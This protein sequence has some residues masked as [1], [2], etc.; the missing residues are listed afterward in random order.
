MLLIWYRLPL[1]LKIAL[2]MALLSLA[3]AL[4]VIGVTQYSQQRLLHERTDGLGNALV[5][6]LAASA[7]RPLVQNDA[8]SLQAALAGFVEEPVVQRAVVFDLKQ[9]LLAAAGDE[10]P[11]SWDYSATIHWQDNA[12]G[13]VVLSLRPS[14]TQGYYPQLGDLMVLAAILTAVSAVCGLWL[15]H[16]GE[17]LLATLTRKL[18]GE[19]VA[20]NY[21]G[22]DVLARLLHI[23]PPPILSA[24]PEPS[25]HGILLLQVY[26]PV[27]TAAACIRALALTE[28]V[29][30]LYGGKSAVTR[31]GGI[32]VRFTADDEFEG[33]FRA[34]C[35]AELLHRLGGGHLRTALAP[36]ARIDA[37]DLWLE[38]QT[39]ERLQRACLGAT[40]CAV[41]IDAQLQRHPALQERTQLEAQADDNWRLVALLSPYDTLVERQINTLTTQLGTVLA[42]FD[43]HPIGG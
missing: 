31:A 8:V 29:A 14:T 38:Q 9:Q 12:V 2:P 40:D 16:S 20:F 36:L 43:E 37:Q 19:E 30:Q 23:T 34:L 13:R 24:Q 6:R 18:S 26:S 10:V 22:T 28:A 41:R 35:C 3:S 42:G 1:A 11:D 33:P 4:A 27:E 7:A 15:G 17:A 21:R 5:S 39:I 32:S 25:Q